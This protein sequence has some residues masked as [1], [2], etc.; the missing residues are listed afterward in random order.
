V[1][2]PS[3]VFGPRVQAITAPCTGAYHLSKRTTQS[4]M[5]GLLGLPMSV[6]S[7]MNLGQASAEALAQPVAEARAYLQTQHAA[8][9]G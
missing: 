1:G 5:E 6:G 3:R 7:M 9:L 2:V 8:Y 4:V